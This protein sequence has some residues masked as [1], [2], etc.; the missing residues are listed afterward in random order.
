MIADD[1]CSDAESV[2]DHVRLRAEEKF[3]DYLSE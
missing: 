3:G 1:F 2:R